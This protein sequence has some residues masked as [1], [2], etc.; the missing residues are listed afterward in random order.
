MVRS[1]FR[2]MCD[3]DGGGGMGI[4]NKAAKAGICPAA[5]CAEFN[6]SLGAFSGSPTGFMIRRTGDTRAALNSLFHCSTSV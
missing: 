3:F 4:F 1:V 6:R 5:I 2:L